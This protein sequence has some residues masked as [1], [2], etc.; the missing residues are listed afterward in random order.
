MKHKLSYRSD[1]YMS[2]KETFGGIRS[3]Y[4]IPVHDK[5]ISIGAIINR[6]IFCHYWEYGDPIRNWFMDFGGGFALINKD[7]G[8]VGVEMKHRIWQRYA[9]AYPKQTTLNFGLEFVP[10]KFLPVRIGYL[11]HWWSPEYPYTKQMIITMGFGIYLFE[12]TKIDFA[13]NYRISSSTIDQVTYYETYHDM[14][15][16]LGLS[17]RFVF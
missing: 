12:R 13:Y 2:D 6:D 9:P 4:K 1:G 5:T 17:G 11:Y 10:L 16:I 14:Q 15:S 7:N 3:I 8:L